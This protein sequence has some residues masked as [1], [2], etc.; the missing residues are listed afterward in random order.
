M[1]HLYI[2]I[3]TVWMV[4]GADGAGKHDVGINRIVECIAIA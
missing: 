1:N 2:N 3:G 4:D